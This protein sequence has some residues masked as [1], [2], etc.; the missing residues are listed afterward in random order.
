MREQSVVI[1][2]LPSVL[3]S[4]CTPPIEGLLAGILVGVIKRLL[5][6]E[7][8]TILPV[9]HSRLVREK[10]QRRRVRRQIIGTGW[11]LNRVRGYQMQVNI[12]VRKRGDNHRPRVR[13]R[14]E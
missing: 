2:I 7:L 6:Q 1:A 8:K 14:Q 13:I 12:V 3:E 5:F 4:A 10:A 9:N 11:F